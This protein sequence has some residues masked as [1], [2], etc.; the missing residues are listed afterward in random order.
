VPVAANF[1]AAALAWHKFVEPDISMTPFMVGSPLLMG[2]W[3][4]FGRLAGTDRRHARWIPWLK[5]QNDRVSNLARLE[6]VTY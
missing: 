5:G 2:L 4:G 3:K 1:E 6:R